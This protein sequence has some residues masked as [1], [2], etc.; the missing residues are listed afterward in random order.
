MSLVFSDLTAAD[1]ADFE[2]QAPAACA[3]LRARALEREHA[4]L[5]ALTQRTAWQQRRL[6]ELSRLHR[7][8]LEIGGVTPIDDTRPQERTAQ[9]FSTQGA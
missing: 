4:R 5:G 1:W 6:E 9:P 2:Q 3:W 8:V 7:F